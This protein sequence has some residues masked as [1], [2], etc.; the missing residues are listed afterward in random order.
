MTAETNFVQKGR[1]AEA[2]FAL[3]RT[4]QAVHFAALPVMLGAQDLRPVG[5]RSR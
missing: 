5:V 3:W 4:Q 1:A 2:K